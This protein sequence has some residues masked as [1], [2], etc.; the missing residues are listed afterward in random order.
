MRGV[1][2]QLVTQ[3]VIAGLLLA[4]ASGTALAQTS[5]ALGTP[6][7][8]RPSSSGSFSPTNPSLLGSTR[9]STPSTPNTAIGGSVT[10]GIPGTLGG[11]PYSVGG[12]LTGGIPGTLGAIPS[13]G[14]SSQS[15]TPLGGA[16]I[17][18]TPIT[19]S[20]I[21]GSTTGAIGGSQTGTI[22]SSSGALG[23]STSG[24][25]LGS[26]LTGTTTGTIR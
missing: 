6:G 2:M 14:G 8:L 10:G 7:T 13:G 19:P 21:G 18:T 11:T 23:G 9:Q 25:G 15:T 1:S 12:S 4:L 24:S 26:G 16:G 5:G 17:S 20:T 3:F 22:G